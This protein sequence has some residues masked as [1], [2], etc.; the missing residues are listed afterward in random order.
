[1]GFWLYVDPLPPSFGFNID[2]LGK[3]IIFHFLHIDKYFYSVK[4]NEYVE[5]SCE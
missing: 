2:P 3:K 1:M 4:R 5:N